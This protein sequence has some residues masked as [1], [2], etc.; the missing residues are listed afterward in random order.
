MNRI[1]SCIQS[2]F[3]NIGIINKIPAA[4]AINNWAG[5]AVNTVSI[6]LTLLFKKILLFLIYAYYL[7]ASEVYKLRGKVCLLT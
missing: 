2:V 7:T 3:V 6:I 5:S 4:A 1:G